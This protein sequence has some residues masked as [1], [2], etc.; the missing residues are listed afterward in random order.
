MNGLTDRVGIPTRAF[1]PRVSLP[2][3]PFFSLEHL[4]FISRRPYVVD[5]AVLGIVFDHG[6]PGLTDGGPVDRTREDCRVVPAEIGVR[7][8]TRDDQ[9]VAIG[10]PAGGSE[11]GFLCRGA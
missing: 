9:K 10:M 6:L 2:D 8:L 11:V 4:Q 5:L 1:R 3:Q 7:L